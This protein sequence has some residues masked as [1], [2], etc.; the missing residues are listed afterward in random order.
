LAHPKSSSDRRTADPRKDPATKALQNFIEE[1][2]RLYAD[3]L[4]HSKAEISD[5]VKVYALISR[6]RVLSNMQTIEKADRVVKMI[7][8]TYFAP[9]KTLTELR[10]MLN[11][12]AID[13]LR[14][15]SETCQK[16]Y[17]AL[18]LLPGDAPS[19]IC[20]ARSVSNRD[21]GG[22]FHRALHSAIGVQA[23]GSS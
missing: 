2:S 3:A 8:D 12:S 4:G 20:A 16:N 22:H 15:F 6:M 5:F 23:S 9:N 17:K 19:R 7:V 11:S 1:T 14:D 18:V 13:P 21:F 10:G